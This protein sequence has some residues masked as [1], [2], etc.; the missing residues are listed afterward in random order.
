MELKRMSV[1]KEHR[2]QGIAKALIGEV[3]R[4]TRARGYR[5]VMLTT[6]NLQ[7]PAM[8]LYEGQGFRKVSTYTPSLLG[9]LLRFKF[10]RYRYDLPG[11]T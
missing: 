5:T 3:L 4:F 11:G 9:V 6:S 1:S 8:R 10:F 7:V 2:G